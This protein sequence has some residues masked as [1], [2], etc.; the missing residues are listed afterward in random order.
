[1]ESKFVNGKGEDMEQKKECLPQQREQ[2]IA[3]L[4]A[5]IAD[6]VE[7]AEMLQMQAHQLSWELI[8]IQRELEGLYLTD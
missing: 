2:Q 8:Q 4:G 1:M 3:K 7:K 6:L 5:R